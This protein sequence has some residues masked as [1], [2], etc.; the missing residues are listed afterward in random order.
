MI[1]ELDKPIR[2]SQMQVFKDAGYM[3]PD[4]FYHNGVFYVQ[5]TNLVATCA[6]GTK[7]ISVR[8]HG[9]GCDDKISAFSDLIEKAVNL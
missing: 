2:K 5:K 8:C 7:R 1:L 6:Y 3:V 4:N 9:P